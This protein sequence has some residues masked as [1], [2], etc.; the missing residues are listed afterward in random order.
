HTRAPPEGAFRCGGSSFRSVDCARSGRTRPTA[1]WIGVDRSQLGTFEHV[2]GVW[3]GIYSR[4]RQ[5]VSG[6][7][8]TTPADANLPTAL[9][10]RIFVD[11]G[12]VS[13]H[14]THSI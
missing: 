12:R 8:S 4:Y 10:R 14:V 1:G 6:F 7:S 13:R 2:R 5:R 11:E 9:V 3:R